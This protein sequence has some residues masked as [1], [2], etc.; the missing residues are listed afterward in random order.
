M[1]PFQRVLPGVGVR[2]RVTLLLDFGLLHSMTK[3]K[4]TMVKP[5]NGLYTISQ[6]SPTHTHT[7]SG[8]MWGQYL[9]ASTCR[10]EEPE[11][12]LSMFRLKP[13]LPVSHSP[14]NAKSSL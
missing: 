7:D 6:H 14:P 8:E 3:R 9:A 5:L 10:L 13:A 4:K 12:E 2:F 1:E 11:I